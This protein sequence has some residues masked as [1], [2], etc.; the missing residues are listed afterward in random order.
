MISYISKNT[1][2]HCRDLFPVNCGHQDCEPSHSFGPSVR[3]R[4]LLH[5]VTAGKG[6][7]TISGKTYT[8]GAGEF[9]FIPPDTLNYYEADAVDPWSYTWIGMKGDLL[10]P[11]FERVGISAE[12]PVGKFTPE[13]YE[14]ARDVLDDI[15]KDVTASLSAV[16]RCYLF[17]HCLERGANR[18][19]VAQKRPSGNVE[20]AR[21]LIEERLHKPLSVSALAQ[22]LGID[23]SYLCSIFKRELGC[24]PQQYILSRKMEKAKYFLSTTTENVKYIALSLGYDDPFVFSRAFKKVTGM[25]P[26]QWRETCRE[27]NNG[28]G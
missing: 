13:L 10:A 4:F 28:E 23:R 6:S 12:N 21:A 16:G 20:R 5:L 14:I 19:E 2:L 18:P 15:S 7:F 8:V 25:S 22:E 11:F 26:G 17:L 9:F 27:K 1:G 24:S 3:D